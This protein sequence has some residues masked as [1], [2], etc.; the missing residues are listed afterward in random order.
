MTN[1]DELPMQVASILFAAAD[2]DKKNLSKL[3]D[4]MLDIIR[5][6]ER[7][8]VRECLE[9]VRLEFSMQ[10]EFDFAHWIDTELANLD[11]QPEME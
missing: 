10:E 3:H 11:A 9:R 8:A 7:S 1:H 2:A 6:R 4:R 5:N